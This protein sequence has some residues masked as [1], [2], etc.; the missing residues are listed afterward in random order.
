VVVF[1][2]LNTLNTSSVYLFVQRCLATGIRLDHLHINSSRRGKHGRKLTQCVQLIKQPWSPSTTNLKTTLLL[3]TFLGIS[4][5]VCEILV[6]HP[7]IIAYVTV[8]SPIGGSIVYNIVFMMLMCQPNF[9]IDVAPCFVLRANR[10]LVGILHNN[11]LRHS[12]LSYSTY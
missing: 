12:A 4:R 2:Y 6:I 11:G 3:K 10:S 8:N 1:K 7:N 9:T 5:K